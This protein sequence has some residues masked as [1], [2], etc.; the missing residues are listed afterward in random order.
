[1]IAGAVFALLVADLAFAKP[2]DSYGTGAMADAG[3]VVGGCC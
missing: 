1:M 3:W 2:T